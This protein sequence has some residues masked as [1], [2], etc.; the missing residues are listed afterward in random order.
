M[1]LLDSEQLAVFLRDLLRAGTTRTDSATSRASVWMLLGVCCSCIGL[2]VCVCVCV[3]VCQCLRICFC[4]LL[5]SLSLSHCYSLLLLCLLLSLSLSLSLS[6]FI[7]SM[8]VLVHRVGLAS[9]VAQVLCAGKS[10]YTA[11]PVEFTCEI[12]CDDVSNT[13]FDLFPSCSRSSTR[14]TLTL[15]SDSIFFPLFTPLFS[16][17]IFHRFFGLFFSRWEI[18]DLLFQEVADVG[19][20][21]S[22]K[23]YD[24]FL[25]LKLLLRRFSSLYMS[26]AW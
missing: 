13:S 16:L 6:L 18:S 23:A 1:R 21:N 9:A 12:T 19:R 22:S 11:V 4:P 26:H 20:V 24:N 10:T 25:P 15:A 3:C 2:A 5:V 7:W 8:Q 14:L 17:Q